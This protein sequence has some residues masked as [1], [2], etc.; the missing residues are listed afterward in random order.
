MLGSQLS[1][2]L[3]SYF[4]LGEPWGGGGK[5]RG[6]ENLTI[7][8]PPKRAFGPPLVRYVFHPS[9]VSVLCFSCT[10][11]TTEQTRSSFG[12]VQ[13]FSGERVLWYVVSPPSPPYHV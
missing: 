3:Q 1:E 9:Q 8:T 12:G 5:K 6:V 11:S 7:D 10:K 4:K 13:K 2:E